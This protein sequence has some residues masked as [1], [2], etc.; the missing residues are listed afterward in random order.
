MIRVHV[1]AN[2]QSVRDALC[3]VLVREPDLLLAECSLE[4]TTGTMTAAAVKPDVIILLDE[5]DESPAKMV[6]AFRNACPQAKILVMALTR[7]AA[8]LRA[9]SGADA[10]VE[11]RA[12]LDDLLAAIRSLA[13]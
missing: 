4:G 11:A 10:V 5:P 6:S 7:S 9:T 3:V 2:P 13:R 8:D 1:A 12:G